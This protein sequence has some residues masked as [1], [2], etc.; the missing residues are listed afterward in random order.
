MNE[1][2]I[3]EAIKENKHKKTRKLKQKLKLVEKSPNLKIN[4]EDI[5]M[6]ELVIKTN[7]YNEAF[8][9]LLGELA[10]LMQ[11]QGEVFR[12]KAYQ[13]AQEAIMTYEGD[14]T[15]AE[16]LKGLRGIGETILSKLNEYIETGMISALEK[17]RKNPVQ[18]FLAK[19]WYPLRTREMLGG[20][21]V[22]HLF[23]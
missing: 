2:P 18:I 10:D 5:N 19:P 23:H 21:Q 20:V 17:Q 9:D 11:A 7:T 3:N 8:I 13:K 12:A 16:Q 4:F 15:N 14:I 22:C 1:P 6:Q